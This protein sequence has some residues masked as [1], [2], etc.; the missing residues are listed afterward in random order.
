M[1]LRGNLFVK[2]FI[3]F[4]LAT[5]TILASWMLSSHYFDTRLGDDQPGNREAFHPHGGPPPRFI[6]R[7]LYNLQHLPDADL[8]D[9]IAELRSRH[10]LEIFLLRADTSDLLDREVPPPVARLAE[11]LGSE[12]RRAMDNVR[13]NHLVAHLIY[14]EGEGLV[15]AVFVLPRPARGLLRALGDKLWLRM[16]LAI[17]ISGL[18]CYLLS[19]L[20]TNRLKELG[21]ASRRLAEGDLD[22]R[23]S[24]RDRGGDET[25]ELARDFNSMASQLQAR[26]NAQKRLL[27]DVSHELRSPLARLR[28]ALALAEDDPENLQSH[29]ERIGRE[30]GRLDELIGQ[31]LA[32]GDGSPVL[33]THI[34]LVALLRQLCADAGFEGR[35]HSVSV[36]F[37]SVLE[38]AVVA[39]ASDLLHKCFENILR[40]A[41]THSPP[42]AVIEVG[43]LEEQAAFVITVEDQG[44]GVPP[45]E[46]D[47]IFNEFHRVDT[48]RT[49]ESGGYGLGLAIAQRAVQRHGGRI[50]A[51]NTGH[52]LRVTV[53]L[54]REAEAHITPGRDS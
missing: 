48:A 26:I 44:P 34:D 2:I 14:R 43:L 20:M 39:S 18:L 41:V 13:G 33:D 23:L 3:G 25:D 36:H 10:G 17:L 15:R 28:V 1:S 54:P 51:D 11:K 37:D 35:A 27:S 5:V 22:T 31:L 46:L 53:F 42:G 6:L 30:T 29:L 21:R 24:V 40:N 16:T 47:S 19:R 38:Q 4:W 7:S 49:R 50:R 9:M 32:A 52:G 45:E 8:R 12:R